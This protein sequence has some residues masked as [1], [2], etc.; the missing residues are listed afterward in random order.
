MGASGE[1][2]D[3]AADVGGPDLLDTVGL[4]AAAVDVDEGYLRLLGVIEAAAGWP[5]PP[6]AFK[7]LIDVIGSA[8]SSSS[9]SLF[10]FLSASFS[11]SLSSAALASSASSS[12]LIFILFGSA[13][14]SFDLGESAEPVYAASSSTSCWAYVIANACA[15][16]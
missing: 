15:L 2:K 7:L 5:D 10:Y 16:N 12:T 6:S 3:L 8:F 13:I 11:D 1:I 9:A 4:P 14:F